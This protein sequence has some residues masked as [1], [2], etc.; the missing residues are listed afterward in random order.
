MLLADSNLGYAGM[1]CKPIGVSMAA[2]SDSTIPPS[3][4]AANGPT[5][6]PV[7]SETSFVSTFVLLI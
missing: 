6:H 3:G 2:G 1:P 5:A 4:P 7:P